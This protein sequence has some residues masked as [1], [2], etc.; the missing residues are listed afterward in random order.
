[1]SEKKFTPGPWRITG[2][3]ISRYIDAPIGNGMLQEV[4]WCGATEQPEQMEANARLIAAA[5][6]MLD[7]LTLMVEQIT[8]PANADHTLNA[9]SYGARIAEARAAIAKATGAQS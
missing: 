6:D 3:G 5:P 2:S 4:A 1:M 9:F 8:D 7:V